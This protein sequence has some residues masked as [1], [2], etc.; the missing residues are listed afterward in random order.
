MC[1]GFSV[2]VSVAVFVVVAVAVAVSVAVNFQTA[3]RT[4]DLTNISLMFLFPWLDW[5]T[6]HRLREVFFFRCENVVLDQCG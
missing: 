3:I 5:G 6:P 4:L 2:A 1:C